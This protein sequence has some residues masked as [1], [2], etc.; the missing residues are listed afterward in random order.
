M[1]QRRIVTL[2]LGLAGVLAGGLPGRL[3]G[4]TGPSANLSGLVRDSAGTPLGDV[5]I[6]I[7]TALVSARSDALG[8]FAVPGLSPG[9]HTLRLEKPGFVPMRLRVTISGD[10]REG[11]ALSLGEIVLGI[12]PARVLS[13]SVRFTDATTG[14]SV[15]GVVVSVGRH[16]IGYGD[17]AGHFHADSVSLRSGEEWS[18]RRLGYQPVR[19]D[20]WPSEGQS[21]VDLAIKLQPIAITLGPVVVV[22]DVSRTLRPWMAD[23][24][25][26]RRREAG[27]FLTEEEVLKHRGSLSATNLLSWAGVE[28]RGDILSSRS[29]RVWGACPWRQGGPPVVFLDGVRL[30][31]QTA[32]DWLDTYSPEQVA[33]VEVYNSPA[34]I[35]P[36]FNATGSDCGVIVV[37]TK[38]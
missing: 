17:R 9:Q 22:G 18:F 31:E 30:E 35:P 16:V 34:K 33:G 8:R 14:R 13:V 1:P 7:D 5:E 36:M 12:S 6:T 28:V 2:L 38:R 20:L 25:E 21:S 10:A 32:I 29:L 23:F 11:P 19:F 37:W 27:T 3:V 24:E 15:E 26:R 4:Q